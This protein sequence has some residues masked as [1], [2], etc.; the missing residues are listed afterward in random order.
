MVTHRASLLATAALLAAGPERAAAHPLHTSYTT[1]TY[2]VTQRALVLSVRAF[3]DDYARAAGA[4][5]EAALLAYAR[6]TVSVSD[7]AGRRLPLA[8]CGVRRSGDLLWLCLR[9]PLAAPPRAGALRMHVTLLAE[10]FA[11]QVNVLQAQ[12]GGATR[13]LLFIRGD[14]PKALP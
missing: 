14:A 8:G 4:G 13:S 1:A 6:R 11:D 2:D 7:A 9:A 5:D 10:R 12:F 3:V